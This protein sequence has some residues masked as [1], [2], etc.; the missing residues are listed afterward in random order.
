MIETMQDYTLEMDFYTMCDD[1]SCRICG[2]PT[3]LLAMESM[4]D[5]K[6]MED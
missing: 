3:D 2:D 1:A 6:V 5:H 4:T